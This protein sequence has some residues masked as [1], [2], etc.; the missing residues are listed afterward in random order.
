MNTIALLTLIVLGSD[1]RM[2]A[3]QTEFLSF[4]D[5]VAAATTSILS[6]RSVA[7]QCEEITE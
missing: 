6:G 7:A 1:G 2:D 4:A 3:Y 5:C